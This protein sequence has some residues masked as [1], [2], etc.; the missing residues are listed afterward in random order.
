M[1][2]WRIG[3]I[4]TGD[5]VFEE[6][7]PYEL[8]NK[9]HKVLGKMSL[10]TC[11]NIS[12]GVSKDCTNEEYFLID[13]STVSFSY[14]VHFIDDEKIYNELEDEERFIYSCIFSRSC[15]GYVRQTHLRKILVDGFPQW[16][17]PYILKLSSEYVV[18]II[19]DIYEYME[20][21]DNTLF[22]VFCENNS[23]MF[24]YS[25]SRMVSYWNEYYRY[26]C[27][28]LH[29]YVGYRLYKQCFG[30]SCKNKRNW[31]L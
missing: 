31:L 11:N 2:L 26:N 4:G 9:V 25:Y 12:C 28:K 21:R 18:E 20:T 27:Y 1:E 14:R 5:I 7:F 3:L 13:G 30:Y 17:M 23:H 19:D 24:R 8:Q 10:K 29:D 22:Q 15:D 6:G 16:C